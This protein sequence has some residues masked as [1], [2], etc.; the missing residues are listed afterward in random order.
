LDRNNLARFEQQSFRDFETIISTFQSM[1]VKVFVSEDLPSSGSGE[2]Y[3]S[4][5]NLSL[6]APDDKSSFSQ[7][8][9]KATRKFDALFM[10][11]LVAASLEDA[12][13]EPKEPKEPICRAVEAETVETPQEKA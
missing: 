5:P 8:E 1:K 11:Y 3:S 6:D 7:P 2:R 9:R 13:K 12:E 10:L 4:F